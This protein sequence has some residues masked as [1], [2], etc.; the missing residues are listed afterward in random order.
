MNKGRRRRWRVRAGRKRGKK[1]VW[2]VS[3]RVRGEK[4]RDVMWCATRRRCAGIVNVMLM[5]LMGSRCHTSGMRIQS[6]AGV[7]LLPVYMPRVRT[8]RPD[9]L[10]SDLREPNEQPRG[11]A[12]FHFQPHRLLLPIILFSSFLFPISSFLLKRKYD[13]DEISDLVTWKLAIDVS[14]HSH[15]CA[16]TVEEAP[17]ARQ[18]RVHL[19]LHCRTSEPSDAFVIMIYSESDFLMNNKR[20]QGCLFFVES[21]TIRHVSFGH[22]STI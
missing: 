3:A 16:T 9:H 7:T 19:R 13:K 8:L 11:V 5:V 1:I 22:A 15:A 12:S 17:A 18:H 21:T 20:R 2:C 10:Q 14:L 4:R 6:H